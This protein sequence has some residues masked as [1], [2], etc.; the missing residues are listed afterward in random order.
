MPFCVAMK[1]GVS[2]PTNSIAF[3][4]DI[5]ENYQK[6]TTDDRETEWSRRCCERVLSEIIGLPKKILCFALCCHEEAK[7]LS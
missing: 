4:P 3:Y 5:C 6:N 1:V 2:K 7:K